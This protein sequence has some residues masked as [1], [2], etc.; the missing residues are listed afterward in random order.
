MIPALVSRF[1]ELFKSTS[2]LYIIGVIEFFRAA[3]IVNNRE[4]A[5][6]EIYTFVASVY[7]VFCYSLSR[8][9]ELMQRRLRAGH[10]RDVERLLGW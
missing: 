2:L 1:V 8:F 10:M 5:S 9:G 3:T 6:F 4:F 7:F